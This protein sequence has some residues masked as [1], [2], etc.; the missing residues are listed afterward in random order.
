MNTTSNA[1]DKVNWLDS[2][3]RAEK[4]E[5]KLMSVPMDWRAPIIDVLDTIGLLKQ[6]LMVH[7]IDDAIVLIEAARMTLERYDKY[8]AESDF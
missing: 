7:G 3:E 8:K 4:W 1:D 6:G 2:V 5:R